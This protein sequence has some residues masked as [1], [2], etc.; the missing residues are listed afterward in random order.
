MLAACASAVFGVERIRTRNSAKQRQAAPVSQIEDL[1]PLSFTQPQPAQG[2]SE[3]WVPPIS[4]RRT[5]SANRG[6]RSAIESSDDDESAAAPEPIRPARGK[7]RPRSVASTSN[8]SGS[9]TKAGPQWRESNDPKELEPPLPTLGDETE[10]KEPVVDHDAELER[11]PA[12]SARNMVPVRKEG[13]PPR[14]AA[15]PA[16]R[17]PMKLPVARPH[18]DKI[19]QDVEEVEEEVAEDVPA[20]RIHPRGSS[21]GA[22]P[23]G[24]RNQR[25]LPRVSH[26]EAVSEDLSEPDE[27]ELSEPPKPP[28]RGASGIRPSSGLSVKRGLRTIA[29]QEMTPLPEPIRDPR[30]LRKISAIQPFYDYEPDPERLKEDRCHNLCPR[31][32]HGCP[33]CKNGKD[34]VACLECPEEVRL[35]DALLAARNFPTAGYWWEASN[36]CYNPLYFEDEHLERYGHTR[37]CLQPLWSVGRFGVQLF[38]LPYQMTIDPVC[39]ARYPLGYYRPGDCVPYKYHQIPLNAE[40]AVVEA[41]VIAGGVLLFAP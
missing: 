27:V 1:D 32:K 36:I 40:A 4:S 34:G 5:A 29:A 31:P 20:R 35:S 28:T 8:A 30:Q 37:G 3:P 17:R 12:I 2:E 33:D 19:E 9:K 7:S 13:A 41:G 39:K 16:P 23:A 15:K 25:V 38:G 10:V 22:V 14:V 24:A 18:R 11:L 26:P 21:I 6:S